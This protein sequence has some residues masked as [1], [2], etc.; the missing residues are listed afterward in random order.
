MTVKQFGTLLFRSISALTPAQKAKIR[1]QI[2][3]QSL[4]KMPCSEM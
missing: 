3:R 2:L 1:A 4:L